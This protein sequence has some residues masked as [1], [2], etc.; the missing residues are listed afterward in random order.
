MGLWVVGGAFQSL[1]NPVAVS[2]S[3][4][5]DTA[6]KPDGYRTLHMV[7]AMKTILFV[8]ALLI[9]LR[10]WAACAQ[11]NSTDGWLLGTSSAL[12]AMDWAQTREFLSREPTTTTTTNS[13]GST[14]TTTTSYSE[15]N[16]ILGKHPSAASVN[17]YFAAV[18]AATWTAG[19]ATDSV[20]E[21][22][23][24]TFLAVLIMLEAYS[25][26]H[27]HTVAATWGF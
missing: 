16:P 23:R 25:V 11:I 27:N 9:P 24:Q 19:C 2:A 26:L 15:Q 17:L 6:P 8:L 5:A 21:D 3:S 7:S 22:T 14:S 20:D 1:T 4:T 10:T 18:L 12:L 13:D